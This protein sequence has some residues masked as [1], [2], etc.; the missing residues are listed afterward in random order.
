MPRRPAG[1]GS[2]PRPARPDRAPAPRDDRADGVGALRR[3]HRG[4][5]GASAGAE[6]TDPEGRVSGC[7]MSQ[8]VTPTSR[9]ASRPISKRRCAVRRS[10]ASS[11]GVSRSISRVASVASLSSQRHG[12][13]AGYAGCCRCRARTGRPRAP[14]GQAQIALE[15]YRARRD[16]DQALVAC[17][18]PC[19]YHRL[20][21][22]T[23]LPMRVS[24][25]T[26]QRERLRHLARLPLGRVLQRFD[27]PCLIEV[28]HGVELVRQPCAEIVAQAL[29]FRVGDHADGPLERG[30]RKPSVTGHPH[31]RSAGRGWAA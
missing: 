25:F 3:R 13:C 30:S 15:R 2:A 19:V 6:V 23:S 4:G 10:I 27:R 21:S 28:D 18:F 29:G 9:S 20:A 31:A 16:A 5:A 1:P 12:D 8:S 7:C 24:P 14:P 17:P 26:L 22:G 11:S